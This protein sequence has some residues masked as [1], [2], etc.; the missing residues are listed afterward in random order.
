MEPVLP[1]ND[2]LVVSI[3][4]TCNTQPCNGVLHFRARL[5]M[6]GQLPCRC[7][8]CKPYRTVL[9]TVQAVCTLCPQAST[10]EQGLQAAL[11][12][13]TGPAPLRAEIYREQ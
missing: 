7:V 9:Q 4:G 13:H 10:R 8:G 11:V 2:D 6:V 1:A 12:L 3:G 5:E